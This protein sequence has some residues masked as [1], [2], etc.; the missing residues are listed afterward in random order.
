[1]NLKLTTQHSFLFAIGTLKT[2]T[3]PQ[4]KTH[5]YLHPFALIKIFP[6]KT[7]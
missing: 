7:S 3:S 1:M 6:S 4:F 5:N 2:H